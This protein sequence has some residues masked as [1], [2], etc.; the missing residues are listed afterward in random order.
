MWSLGKVM[1]TPEV[2][3]VY[4]GSF[5]D[6]KREKNDNSA[7]FEREENDLL[8]ELESLP[9]RAPL[10]KLNDFIRRAALAKV[11]A[12]IMS[13]LYS[14]MPMLFGKDSAKQKLIDNLSEVYTKVQQKHDVPAGDFPDIERMKKLLQEFDFNQLPSYKEKLI[15][16][17]EKYVKDDIPKLIEQVSAEISSAQAMASN[18]FSVENYEGFNAG[19]D[20]PDVWIVEQH[21]ARYDSTFKTM[22]PDEQGKVSI[23]EA[24]AQMKK[25]NLSNH[26]LK[27]IWYLGDINKD[28]KLDIDEWALVSY[29]IELKLAGHD[30][31]QTL[32]EHLVPP[33]K[34]KKPETD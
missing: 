31:P 20:E 17:T 30:L 23:A 1:A 18:I 5:W 4:V 22:K 27:K 34:R 33:S 24:S 29:I 10:R 3:R 2:P 14:D 21:R 26:V 13:Q 12:L 15:K 11:H 9:I 32:P 8:Q 7:L 16:K 28:D 6:Q 19:K 25:S